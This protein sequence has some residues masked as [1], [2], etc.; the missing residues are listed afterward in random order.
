M[1]E[2]GDAVD[3]DPLRDLIVFW[4]SYIRDDNEIG[5]NMFDELT[6]GIQDYVPAF[7]ACTFKSGD[8]FGGVGGN[9]DLVEISAQE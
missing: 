5:G 4:G 1:N 8:L 6:G 2:L 9:V 7:P 3:G